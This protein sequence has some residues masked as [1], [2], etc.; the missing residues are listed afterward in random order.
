MLRDGHGM[1]A[2]ASRAWSRVSGDRLTI[3]RSCA[4]PV[5]DGGDEYPP[6]YLGLAPGWGAGLGAAMC[7]LG[8]CGDLVASAWKRDAGVKDSGDLLPGQGGLLDRSRRGSGAPEMRLH[9]LS[10]T[11]LEAR[12]S[13]R[14]T[15][16]DRARI[17][18]LWRGLGAK[19]ER[20]Q[21]VVKVR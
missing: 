18:V 11:Q 21:G 6:Q 10:T 14:L 2:S 13:W 1:T 20:D 15:G 12:E 17:R 5:A 9:P 16:F 19:C 4:S 8:L 3:M 7:L